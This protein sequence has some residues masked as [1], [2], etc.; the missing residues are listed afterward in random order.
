MLMRMYA[1]WGERNGYKVHIYDL[2]EGDEAGIKSVTIEFEGD[3]AYGY[4]K[5]ENGVHRLVRFHPLTLRERDR[6][7]SHRY[8]SIRQLMILLKL[9]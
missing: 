4:L 7:H 6:P 5:A 8:L 1:R 3:Y 2:I 9:R